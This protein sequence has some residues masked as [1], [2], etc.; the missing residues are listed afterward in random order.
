MAAWPGRARA[1]A[2][3]QPQA[4]RLVLR[5]LDAGQRAAQLE[6]VL[7][8]Q[9]RA[10]QVALLAGI[11]VEV[12][13]MIAAELHAPGPER[14]QVALGEGLAQHWH[15]DR[16]DRLVADQRLGVGP[17][18]AHERSTPTGIANPTTDAPS[19]LQSQGRARPTISANRASPSGTSAATPRRDAEPPNGSA[20]DPHSESA[21][22]TAKAGHRLGQAH[23]EVQVGHQLLTA[24]IN[25]FGGVGSMRMN[26]S[27]WRN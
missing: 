13:Q 12:P 25:L 15:I 24:P 5:R 21:G 14:Q 6:R 16:R 19:T 9:R 8:L 11:A 10:G 4:L 18:Q 7:G 27:L 26:C 22:I 1:R 2:C 17:P 23:A 20:T 3:R